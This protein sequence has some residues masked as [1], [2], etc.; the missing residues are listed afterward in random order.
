M[1]Y[2]LEELK[3]L[4]VFGTNNRCSAHHVNR[5]QCPML[6]KPRAQT[7]R[8][9]I[10]VIHNLQLL[11][12]THRIML[13]FC[14]DPAGSLKVICLLDTARGARALCMLWNLRNVVASF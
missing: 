2:Y 6:Y 5:R 11:T 7:C 12:T 3:Y 8:C 14:R 4:E 9:K 13:W 1:S 10:L